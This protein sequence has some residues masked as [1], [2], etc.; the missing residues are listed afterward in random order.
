MS[1]NKIINDLGKCVN[2]QVTVFAV[3][4]K[5]LKLVKYKGWMGKMGKG[6]YETGLKSE[7]KFEIK[8]Y[9]LGKEG[10]NSNFINKMLCSEE[11]IIS[12]KWDLV[13]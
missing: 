10:N 12:L 5:L 1:F 11:T 7:M 3:H 2:I 4:I 13:L 8:W 6:P 9:I